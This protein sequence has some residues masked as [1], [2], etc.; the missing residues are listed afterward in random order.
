MHGLLRDLRVAFRSLARSPGFTATGV[1]TLA[2]G[3]GASAAV[4]TLLDRVV[5]DPLPYPEA[6]RLVQLRNV[7]P[8]VGPDAAWHASTAQYVYFDEHAQSLDEVG[9][10]RG[11]GANIETPEGPVRAFGWRV[12]ASV[13]R[14]LGAEPAT[15]R[16]LTVE[17]DTPGGPAVLVLSHGFWQ[18]Q[19]GG[20]P[21]AVGGTIS[22]D[23]RA[24]EVVGVLRPGVRMPGAPGRIADLWLPMRVDRSGTFGNNHV[25][26]MIA[27]LAPGV[28]P[29]TA[30]AEIARF[31]PRLPER[32]PDAYSQDFFDRYGFRTIVAPLKQ[33]VVGEMASHLWILFAGV[34]LL[35][36]IA[37]INVANLFLV[38][39]EERRR[40]LGIR[41]ALGAGRLTIAR[42][43]LA[44]SLLLTLA[45][46]VLALVIGLLGARALVSLTPEAL[47][48][49]EAVG[50]DGGTALFLLSLCAV[51]AL[52]I[53]AYP[54]ARP[55]RPVSVL[56]AG[57][58]ASTVG[59]T[60]QR[61]R[62]MLVVT[63]VALA[64]A[65]V[66]GSGL[67][68]RSLRELGRLDPGIDPEG[69]TTVELHLSPARY[70]NGGAMWG[71]YRGI[72][73]QVR[74]IPGVL[75]AGMS[76]ELPIEG[77]FGCTVQGFEES[78]VYERVKAAG[79]T[80]CAGRQATTPGYFEAA[81][82]PLLAGRTFVDADND[83]P[84]RG[85]AVVSRAF[86]ERFWPGEDPIG[87]GVASARTVPPWYRV[88]GVVGDVPAGSLEAAPAIAVYYPIVPH[89]ET[90][91][92]WS[93]WGPTS[94]H[95]VIRTNLADPLSI[96]P[97][98]RRVV[99]EVD[100]TIPL[101][102]ARSLERIVADSKARFTFSSTLLGV[103]S[104]IAVLLAAVG[105]YSVVAYVVTRST[106]EIGIRI[107]IGARPES[108]RRE[109]VARSLLLVLGGLALGVPLVLLAGGLLEGLLYGTSPT[110]PLTI[111]A[112]SIVLACVAALA[113]WLPARRAARVDPAETLRHE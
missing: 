90:P 103:A 51:V 86:A 58:R 92:G 65:L 108:V 21:G 29:A 88:V 11:F 87:K 44:E 82:I 18:R 93:W 94:M 35:L 63:Q 22:V 113:S 67:M 7:V 4:F 52:G 57:G 83:S 28:E 75:E 37:W 80:T 40:E 42:H 59:R 54:L 39:T 78:E 81:G 38:R 97:G 70:E 69:V 61:V 23:G 111:V 109:V 105:L 27:R 71:A 55:P 9:V 2:L 6:D 45:G 15:G 99:D 66:V 13:L 64:L 17:D 12:T 85:A 76:E 8:G 49:I 84:A 33:A 24:F 112:A 72:L 26:P 30:E 107:A 104:A 50:L 98:V 96:V 106:R 102:H 68:L 62:G 100:P 19:F 79:Q 10:Y 46:G 48:R 47:P 31:T 101:V 77:S 89:P 95:L 74:A 1:I 56:A 60:R 3:L 91:T 73:D 14:L 20:D 43:Q 53:A 110:D 34:A 16:L 25:F 5:L 32:F 36:V 41:S